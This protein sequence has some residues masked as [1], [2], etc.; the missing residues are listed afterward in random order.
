SKL[1]CNPANGKWK[2][3]T[4]GGEILGQKGIDVYC[5]DACVIENYYINEDCAAD[6]ECKPF[7]SGTKNCDSDYGLQVNFGNPKVFTDVLSVS[8]AKYRFEFVPKNNAQIDTPNGIRCIRKRIE[9]FFDGDDCENGTG[10]C[11]KPTNC[12]SL[13]CESQWNLQ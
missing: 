4:E 13:Q 2:A 9:N 7:K 3:T 6:E 5:H 8:C 10:Q 12:S 1:E 11:E